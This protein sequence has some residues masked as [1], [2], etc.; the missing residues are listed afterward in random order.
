M[1]KAILL[2][3]I[4]MFFISANSYAGEIFSHRAYI[5][6]YLDGTFGP[7]KEL[8]RAEVAKIMVTSNELDIALG[9]GFYDVEDSHWASSYISTAKLNGYING[10]EDGSYRPDDSITRV[11]FAS[12]IYR[13]I[14]RYVPE[15]LKKDGNLVFSDIKG[16]WGRV[17]INVLAKLGVVKGAGDGSFSPDGHITRAEAVTIVNRV[18]GR[19]PDAEKI[20]GISKAVYKDE[21]ISSHWGY[22][23]IIEASVDHEF[24]IVEDGEKNQREF[25]TK[26][27]F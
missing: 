5:S 19:I 17:P 25:W 1:K 22:Y 24:Y 20:D 27:Y 4:S 21:G 10:N 12:I 2:V 3:G 18:Q 9:S 23:D 15:D 11:E 8:A 13:S 14:E 7:D 6:G 26:F 16:H